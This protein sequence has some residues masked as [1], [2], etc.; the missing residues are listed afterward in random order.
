MLNR[1]LVVL[2][3]FDPSELAITEALQLARERDTSVLFLGVVPSLSVPQFD[4]PSLSLL[5]T[6]QLQAA[7]EATLQAR[8]DG[9]ITEATRQGVRHAVRVLSPPCSARM[10]VAIAE[11]EG[12]D[13][14]LIASDGRSALG[15]LVGGSRIPGLITHAT[16]PIIICKAQRDVAPAI[17]P[18]ARP[19]P[20]P[21]PVRRIRPRRAGSLGGLAGAPA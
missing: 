11:Q 14:I 7:A 17:A 13:A 16:M 3:E 21:P 9:A 6:A 20:A 4:V 15:R 5:G 18:L 12:C 19:T 10:V 1:L 2:D 8:I